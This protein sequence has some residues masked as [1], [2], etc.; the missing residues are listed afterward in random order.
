MRKLL[1]NRKGISP[2]ISTV[3][4]VAV[5]IAVAMAVAFW[6]TGVVGIFTGQV[7]QVQIVAAIPVAE[8]DTLTFDD[9]QFDYVHKVEVTIKNSGTTTVTI[10]GIF[11][12]P[13]S[14]NGYWEFEVSNQTTKV[15]PI[16]SLVPDASSQLKI[17]PGSSVTITVYLSGTM[18]GQSIEIK[19]H[20]ASGKEYPKLVTLP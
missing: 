8:E 20:S 10:D 11:I 9:N 16:N 17:D 13:T 18:A 14:I 6:M 1:D 7:E 4:I 19:L 15:N 2:V 12:S 5:A 3:I